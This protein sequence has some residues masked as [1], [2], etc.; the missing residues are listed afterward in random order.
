MQELINL[1]P[2]ST[3]IKQIRTFIIFRLLKQQIIQ[4][5]LSH[6]IKAMR[7]KTGIFQ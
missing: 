5:N 3:T 4:D 1:F 7:I 2:L 6:I